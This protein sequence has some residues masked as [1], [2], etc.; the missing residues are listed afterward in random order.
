MIR[1]VDVEHLTFLNVAQS[2]NTVTETHKPILDTTLGYD[3]SGFETLPF[4][5][6]RYDFNLQEMEWKLLQYFPITLTVTWLM[7]SNGKWFLRRSCL[8]T[9]LHNYK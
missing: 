1:A 9:C 8:Q 3:T 6:Y 2:E 4:V 7:L 5:I